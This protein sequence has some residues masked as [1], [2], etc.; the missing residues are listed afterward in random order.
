M[1]KAEERTKNEP[2]CARI[3]AKNSFSQQTGRHFFAIIGR[4]NANR[5]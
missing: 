5:A 4:V 3:V 1:L 2:S